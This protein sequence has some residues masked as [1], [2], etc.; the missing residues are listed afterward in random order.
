VSTF[1]YMKLLES[2]ATRYD[3]LMRWLSGGRVQRLYARV[4]D[5][6]RGRKD[7]LDLGT[8]T[9]EIALACARRGARVVGVD[10]NA[11][12]LQVASEKVRRADLEDRVSLRELTVAELEDVFDPGEF[13]AVSACLLMS[14][15][16]EAERAYALGSALR[17]L[18]PGGL[19]VI[20]DE[21]RPPGGASQA[22]QWIR[23]APWVLL[24]SAGPG[25][26]VPV[27]HLREQVAAAGFV[28]VAV[29]HA[30]PDTVVLTA[31]RPEGALT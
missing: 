25:V 6:L 4:S 9:G 28:D 8:G 10:R 11:E 23:R 29:E 16:D 24:A 1:A 13:D 31:H 18:R 14:E 26:S 27:G 21:V 17:L 5:R 12:M 20:G 7:V 30:S 15:L 3:W 2:G 19:L 22:W